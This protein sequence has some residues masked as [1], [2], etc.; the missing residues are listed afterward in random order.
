MRLNLQSPRCK[1]LLGVLLTIY[2]IGLFI[3]THMP[4]PAGA[5]PGGSDKLVH[6]VAYCGL[7]CLLGLVRGPQKWAS[8]LTIVVVF[9]VVDEFLQIPMG[10]SCEV[11]D[12]LADWLGAAAGTG[13]SVGICRRLS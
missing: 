4:M 9:A 6:F 3:G 5:L 11:A 1:R 2:W 10:R 8:S 12:G 13:L 7:A